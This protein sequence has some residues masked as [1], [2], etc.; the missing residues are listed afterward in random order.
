MTRYRRPVLAAMAGLVALGGLAACEPAPPPTSF[1]VN[2][3][4][5]LGDADPGD[6]VCEATAGQGN[7][8]LRAAVEEGNATPGAIVI[9]LAVPPGSAVGFG[10]E[11]A[12]VDGSTTIIGKRHRIVGGIDHVQG[13]LVLRDV[14]L[15]AAAEGELGCG[16]AVAS[17]G[18]SLGLER[19]LID[20]GG[21]V[22]CA[23]GTLGIVASEINAGGASPTVV[24]SG[25][26]YVDRTSVGSGDR[27]LTIEGAGPF[28]L[29]NS[30]LPG[31]QV[32]DAA[33]RVL[34]SFVTGPLTADVEVGG[35][36]LICDDPSDVTSLGHNLDEGGR[37]GA[38]GPADQALDELPIDL[39]DLTRGF[40]VTVMPSIGAPSVGAI[41]AGTPL[42][43][44]GT[45]PHDQRGE[46]RDPAKP[47]DIGPA[48]TQVSVEV[49]EE[50]TRSV[51]WH[52]TTHVNGHGTVAATFPGEGDAAPSVGRWAADGSFTSS[53]DPDTVANDIDDDG[54]VVGTKVVSGNRV[55]WVWPAD[56]PAQVVDGLPGATGGEVLLV[57]DGTIVGTSWVG[58]Q[59]KLWWRAP[60][61]AVQPVSGSDQWTD[62][63]ALSDGYL[64][65]AIRYQEGHWSPTATVWHLASGTMTHPSLDELEVDP[66]VEAYATAR[67]D[68]GDVYGEVQG[69]VVVWRADGSVHQLAAQY[70]GRK[71][72]LV[73]GRPVVIS[74]LG[75]W[76]C[77]VM[78]FGAG[79]ATDARTLTT[80]I[81]AL[82]V[83]GDGTVV[84][85]RDGQLVRQKLLITG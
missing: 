37:C 12:V 78:L 67:S 47:C 10:E 36:L 57:D 15:V 44:D 52:S 46:V 82:D 3:A 69:R 1:S 51:A 30:L 38:D 62:A 25:P 59:R 72:A 31:L 2:D 20:G 54:T 58:G 29:T 81:E 23:S 79:T 43:C 65:G 70:G 33:G 28:H 16:T 77:T 7:C 76:T 21:T 26:V 55:P 80:R 75:C 42:L 61:G 6:G 60:G 74:E 84:G 83:G 73:D 64:M 66:S 17:T 39:L 68:D 50:Q 56:G 35:S 71:V 34:L 48:Q 8:T 49:G 14:E 9:D 18:S 45:V 63:L 32:G 19:V 4:G 22:V 27:G 5:G 53:N 13:H 11:R 41:P 40:P 24:G 85:I